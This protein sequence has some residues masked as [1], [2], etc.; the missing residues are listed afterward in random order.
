MLGC[1]CALNAGFKNIPCG[2]VII[3]L[4]AKA[5]GD[6]WAGV[7]LRGVVVKGR[8]LLDGG[9]AVG[10]GSIVTGASLEERDLS[11]GSGA[12]SGG[13]I[14]IGEFVGKQE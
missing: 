6:V 2:V 10:S 9:G 8:N 5:G 4:S 13:G 12:F 7:S 3:G 11:V 14:A 1:A